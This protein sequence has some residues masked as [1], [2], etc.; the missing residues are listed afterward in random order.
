MSLEA[1]VIVG[2]ICFLDV[3]VTFFEGE[4][5]PET[6]VLVPK[7]MF[8]RYVLPGLMLQLLVNPQMS[9]FSR[10]LVALVNRVLDNDPVRVW[11]WTAAL[12]FPFLRTIMMLMFNHLWIPLV[13]DQNTNHVNHNIGT[14]VPALADGDDDI[15]LHTSMQG[16]R[17]SSLV[18]DV[19]TVA[20][21]RLPVRL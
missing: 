18:I 10:I 16:C 9:Q 14:I 7:P 19:S 3:F 1:M 15:H 13:R 2:T 4:L 17:R 8:K 5:H 6:G 11:R 12:F 20:D 21:F